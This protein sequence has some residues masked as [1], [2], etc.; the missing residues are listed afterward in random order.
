MH[1]NLTKGMK[2]GL[3][4]ILLSLLCLSDSSKADRYLI[5]GTEFVQLLL[6]FPSLIAS[7][8]L[9]FILFL[10]HA[11]YS[12]LSIKPLCFRCFHSHNPLCHLIK[13]E[14]YSSS[15]L[16]TYS[17]MNNF[18]SFLFNHYF[19]QLLSYLQFIMSRSQP[20]SVA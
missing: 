4:F 14:F 1:H 20:A 7:L 11:A 12:F 19:N 5:S 17:K 10:L 13:I 9:S 2:F 3:F 15:Y 6:L 8:L 16:K 18:S